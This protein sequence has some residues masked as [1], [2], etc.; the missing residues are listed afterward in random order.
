MARHRPCAV[1]GVVRHR[2]RAAG[3]VA[4][5]RQRAEGAVPE[6]AVLE[7]ALRTIKMTAVSADL[8]QVYCSTGTHGVILRESLYGGGCRLCSLEYN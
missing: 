6:G 3:G 2:Q 7:G 5:H 8:L 4:R 1:G